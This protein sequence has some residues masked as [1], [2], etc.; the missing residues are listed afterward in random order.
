MQHFT[1]HPPPSSLFRH[2]L[3]RTRHLSCWMMTTMT[4]RKKKEKLGR[5]FWKMSL[6][7]ISMMLQGRGHTYA[8]IFTTPEQKTTLTLSIHLSGSVWK[9]PTSMRRR[10]PAMHWERLPS[11]L[12]NINIYC[13]GNLILA[14]IRRFFHFFSRLA[15]LRNCITTRSNMCAVIL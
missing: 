5:I 15:I 7:L 12:G 11:A 13:K 10:M 8:C 6:R 1:F 4:T 2:T 3:R 9:T 14:F